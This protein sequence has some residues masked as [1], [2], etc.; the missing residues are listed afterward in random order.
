M[1]KCSFCVQRI[2]EGKCHAKDENRQVQAGDITPACAQ[3]CPTQAITFGN[4]KD[5]ESEVARK[6]Q[7][8]L[9]YT[10]FESLNTKPAITYMM[11][12]KRARE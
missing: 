1:E 10:V 6:S 12:I 3:P 4:L 9:G 8:P 7:S 5:K 11:K 2:Q